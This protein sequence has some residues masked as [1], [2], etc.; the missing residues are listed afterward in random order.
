MEMEVI[1]KILLIMVLILGYKDQIQAVKV[2]LRPFKI[3]FSNLNEPKYII[4][5]DALRKNYIQ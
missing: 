2:K 1:K 5:I 3:L 4:L